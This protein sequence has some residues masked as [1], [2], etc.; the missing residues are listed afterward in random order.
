MRKLEASTKYEVCGRPRVRAIVGH[1]WPGLT[2]CLLHKIMSA[3]G[4]SATYMSYYLI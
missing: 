1:F 2:L 3:K 4:A